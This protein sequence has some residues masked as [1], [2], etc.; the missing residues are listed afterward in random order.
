MGCVFQQIQP[1]LTMAA[2][3]SVQSPFTN[4][5]YRDHECEVRNMSA[6]I[7]FQF[8]LIENKMSLVLTGGAKRSRIGSRWSNHHFECIQRMART[9]T[10]PIQS[11]ARKP[12]GVVSTSRPRRATVLRNHQITE[13]ISRLITRLW[14]DGNEWAGAQR[15]RTGHTQGWI[16]AIERFEAGAQIRSATKTKTQENECV[17]CRRRRRWRWWQ[18]RYSRCWLSAQ[19]WCDQNWCKYF[20]RWN[21]LDTFSMTHFS[22]SSISIRV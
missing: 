10:W 5:A 15:Q 7:L 1:V 21:V 22:S 2:A 8:Y 11:K 13:S 17:E 9:K 18:G 14:F 6:F 20:F 3:L 19:S 4:R 16:A 12:K